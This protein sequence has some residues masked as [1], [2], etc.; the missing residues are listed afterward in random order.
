MPNAAPVFSSSV[1]PDKTPRAQRLIDAYQRTYGANGPGCCPQAL[2][3]A[4]KQIHPTERLNEI[5]A[6]LSGAPVE[7]EPTRDKPFFAFSPAIGI[8]F[9][10]TAE[11]AEAEANAAIELIREQ[12]ELEW[13]EGVYQVCWGRRLGMAKKARCSIDPDYPG[14]VH[15]DYEL[16]TPNWP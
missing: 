10:A 13:P 8:R 6:E 2:A 16:A 12:M 11:A 3:A 5:A 1:Q 4:I 14:G 15:E 7:P 9:F